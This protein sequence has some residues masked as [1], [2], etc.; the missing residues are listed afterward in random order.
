[1]QTE[2][3]PHTSC[4]SNPCVEMGSKP[5]LWQIRKSIAVV[6][7]S[8]VVTGA[9]CPGGLALEAIHNFAV[10][11]APVCLSA[12]LQPAQQD[13]WNVVEDNG[14]HGTNCQ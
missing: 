11:A 7:R 5:L 13:F 3:T 6:A 14:G 4:V 10:E 12:L 8:G 9:A 1:M 2:G